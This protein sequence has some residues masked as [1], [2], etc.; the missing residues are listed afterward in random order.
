MENSTQLA[1]RFKEVL[2]NGKW[3]SNNNFK[4]L[5]EDLPWEKATQ[6]VGSLNTIAALA[7]HVNYYVAGVL[8]VFEGGNLEIRDKYSFDLKN[9]ENPTDWKNFLNSMWSNAEKF[10]NHVERMTEEQLGQPFVDE[11]YGTYRRNIEGMIEH[12]YY[13]LGQVSLLLKL[14]AK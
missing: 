5:L 9:L 14:M 4:M 11:K 8:N 2:L 1:N 10:A 12:C 13:H 6:K 7:Y 3:I